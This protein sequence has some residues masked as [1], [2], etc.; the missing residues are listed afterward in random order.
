MRDALLVPQRAT[1]ELQG[2]HFVYLVQPDDTVHAAEITVA[3]TPDG[4]SYVAET[5][6]RAGD[7]IVLDGLASLKEGAK[8]KPQPAPLDPDIPSS[9]AGAAR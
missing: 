8:I 4:K 7:R 2:K 3:A 5:G 6:L 9:P 1:Y